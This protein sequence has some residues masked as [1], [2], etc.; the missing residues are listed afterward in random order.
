M[1]K[2]KEYRKQ[3]EKASPTKP[4]ENQ[5]DDRENDGDES[6]DSKLFQSL[7]QGSIVMEN[8]KWSDVAGL[9]GAKEALREAVIHPIKF[10]H[11]ITGKRT[12]W[13]G[14]LLFGAPGTG[15]TYL[16]KAV[17]T[18]AYG[19]TF[20]VSS[21]DL[22]SK[23]LG[24]NRMLVKNLFSLARKRKPSIIFIDDIDSLCCSRREN[25]SEASQQAKTE[26]LAQ[27][28]GVGN[29]NEGILVLGAT[30]IPWT[31]DPAIRRRFEKRIYVPLPEE[32]ARIFMFKQHLGSSPNS[33][34]ESDFVT[35]GQK[36]E[37]YSGADISIIARDALMQPVRMVQY[38]TH[39][40]RVRGAVWNDP[41]QVM[42]DLWA[43]CS[44][45]DPIAVEMTWKD[46][47]D[48]KLQ[49]PVVSMSHVLKSLSNTK[50]TVDELD[51]EK[52]KEFMED[53]GQEG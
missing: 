51:L 44:P 9:E 12:P 5:S 25:E 24:D 34:T 45:E 3:K 18:E 48:S 2:L 13:M 15:K 22:V 29:D 50:P 27:M 36:T 26:F 23:W 28:Q 7:L 16:A 31:L 46:I 39:F 1:E 14:V 37:G 32:Q 10:P 17:A 30:S 41:G 35:L 4:V 21:S 19:S 53:F 43:P 52:L 20:S 47:Q 6:D 33:L 42:D 38:A 8:V 49:E 40:K 11:L